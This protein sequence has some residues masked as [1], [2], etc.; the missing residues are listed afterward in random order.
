MS[1]V[2]IAME[3]MSRNLKYF[4]FCT[5]LMLNNSIFI[6]KGIKLLAELTGLTIKLPQKKYHLKINTLFF[7]FY[8]IEPLNNL[9]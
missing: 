7:N 1:Q 4:S 6:F 9:I 3:K 8:L 5:L 2:S